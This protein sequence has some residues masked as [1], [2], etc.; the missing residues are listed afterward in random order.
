MQPDDARWMALAL[1]Y[2]HRGLGRVAPNPAVGC[3]IIKNGRVLAAAR[4]AD[5]GRPHA[6]TVALAKAGVAAHGAT[7]YVTLEPCAHIGKTPPCC[8]ALIAAGIKRVVCAL[9]DPDSRVSG[10]GFAKLR[11]AN[12]AVDK[13]VLAA[14]AF[15]LNAG[16][17]KLRRTGLPWLTLKLATSLDGRIATQ[18]GESRWITGPMARTRLHLMRA[19]ND[20]VMVGAGTARADD[21]MLDV[22]LQ[23]YGGPLPVRIVISAALN[24]PRD[25][26][27]AKTARFQRVVLLCDETAPA[28]TQSYWRNA[29]AEVIQCNTAS[30]DAALRALG[31]LGLTRVLCEGGGHLAASL[32]RAGLVDRLVLFTAGLALGATGLPAIAAL[33]L[34][35]L[36]EHP[37]FQMISTENLADDV[38]SH[39]QPV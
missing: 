3:V 39:W 15:A 25:S 26:R 21:P 8:E 10:L 33:G 14:E 29:G 35:S 22:R 20:A 18:S 5:G 6:E 28:E 31:A 1:R 13:G 27:L 36:A 37:R 2:A 9:Q 38:L 17:L 32:L 24:L 16:Y 11:A 19:Q 34:A 30:P 12:V 4:T 7:A 23:G